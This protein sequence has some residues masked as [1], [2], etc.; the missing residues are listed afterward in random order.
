MQSKS[1]MVKRERAEERERVSHLIIMF[2]IFLCLIGVA[3]F[4]AGIHL[5]GDSDVEW[6]LGENDN[7]AL[8]KQAIGQF[9]V[10]GSILILAVL[11][12]T[13]G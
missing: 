7:K 5:V 4:F 12:W 8:L 11:G 2:R 13:C 10:I 9:C 6:L 1:Q 3:L